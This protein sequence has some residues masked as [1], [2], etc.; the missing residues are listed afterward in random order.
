MRTTKPGGRPDCAP[1]SVNT[2]VAQG[3]ASSD[4]PHT[5]RPPPEDVR[6]AALPPLALRLARLATVAAV[7]ELLRRP[8]SSRGLPP[9]SALAACVGKH[10]G[11]PQQGRD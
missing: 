7:A 11:D 2:P 10:V 3:N 9:V 5:H 1:R 8:A 4:A 6:R